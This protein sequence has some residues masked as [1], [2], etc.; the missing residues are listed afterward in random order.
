MF[1]EDGG[2]GGVIWDGACC[3]GVFGASFVLSS[4]WYDG[5][6]NGD[7]DSDDEICGN[8]PFMTAVPAA[9]GATI[10]TLNM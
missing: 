8:A 9:S 3:V 4:P 2:G 10:A 5:A 1:R 6:G 7:G